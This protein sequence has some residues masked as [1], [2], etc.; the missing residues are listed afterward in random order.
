ML[1]R[2]SLNLYTNNLVVQF[3]NL[4]HVAHDPAVFLE[5]V[6]FNFPNTRM[7][8]C[9]VER[10]ISI[11]ERVGGEREVGTETPEALWFIDNLDS[12]RSTAQR[13]ADT[14]RQEPLAPTWDMLRSIALAST[15]W[16]VQ[17][18]NEQILIDSPTTLSSEQFVELLKYRQTLRDLPHEQA[19]PTPPVFV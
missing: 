16:M 3:G 1:T 18:H 10:G 2:F 15:D 8:D 14:H 19:I 9:E 17:R 11:V 5:E 4:I 7:F 12:I 13:E 6:G